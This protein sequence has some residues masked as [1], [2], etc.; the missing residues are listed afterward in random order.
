MSSRWEG[1]S[2]SFLDRRVIHSPNGGWFTQIWHYHLLRVWWYIAQKRNAGREHQYMHACVP[3]ANMHTNIK[4]R[5]QHISNQELASCLGPLTPCQWHQLMSSSLIQ[6]PSSKK[7]ISFLTPLCSSCSGIASSLMFTLQHP[8]S[9]WYHVCTLIHSPWSA[10]SHPHVLD[11][12]SLLLGWGVR[13]PPW[14]SHAWHFNLAVKMHVV[15]GG[16]A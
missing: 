12:F 14:C 4:H 11:F 3:R 5:P 13:N 6:Q 2:F 8:L 10:H 1:S 16:V 9:H 15:V 7:T